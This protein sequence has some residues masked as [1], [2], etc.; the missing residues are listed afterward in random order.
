MAIVL[1]VDDSKVDQRLAGKLIESSPSLGV[2][3]RYAGDG[4][5]ALEA[6]AREVPRIVV[7]D[8]QMPEMDGLALTTAIRE[9]HPG[10]P[11]VLM[12]AHGSEEVAAEAL[13]RGAA[14]YVPKKN[15]AEDLARTVER[16]ME[17]AATA[18]DVEALGEFGL[19]VETMF[20]LGPDSTKIHPVIRY[21]RNEAM[22]MRL[23]D[24]TAAVRVGVALSEAITNAIDHGNLEVSSDLHEQDADAFYSLLDERRRS[25]PYRDRRVTVHAVV[26]PKRAVFTVKDQGKGFDA[27][28]V[29]DPTDSENLDK[30]RGRGVMLMRMFMDDVSFENNGSQVTLVKERDS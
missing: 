20:T 26:T 8:L 18:G 7:T 29:P 1:I 25:S 22:R 3:V 23:C 28:S 16:V 12:T 17:S 4:K 14:S 6:I 21:L 9:R 13:R 30:I 24:E 5:Q 11:V 10:V 15:L 2:T 19:R 27:S